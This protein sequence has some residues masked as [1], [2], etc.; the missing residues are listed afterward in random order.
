MTPERR[1]PLR[2]LFTFAGGTGHANPLVP[3][4]RAAEAA[5]HAVAFAGS[6]SAATALEEQGFTL[7]A[8]PAGTPSD[9]A[10]ITRL[11]E[12]DMEHEYRVLRDH[13]AG[14]LARD[15]ARRVLK[16]AE[17]WKPDL[18]V[19]DEVD[20]GSMVAAE[21][22]GL[23]HATVLVVAVGSFVRPDVVAERLDALRAEHGLRPDPDLTM[24]GRHLVV[25]PIPP[26]FRDPAYRLP[27]NAL[28]VQPGTVE[29]AGT[30]LTPS[31]L[32]RPSGRPTVYF[33]LGT[34]FNLESGDLFTRVLSGLRQLPVD[35]VV[36]VGRDIDPGSFGPQ[37]DNVHVEGYV[38]QSALLP[39]CALVV[40]HGGSG[41]VIGALTHGLPMVVIPMGADQPLN[42]ARCEQLG[43]GIA[44]DAV[45]ATPETIREA[46]TTILENP[47]YRAAA[48]RI[49][50]EIVRLPE[51]DAAVPLLE[52][53]AESAHP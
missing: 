21:R 7:F 50:D 36:T 12:L 48:E 42:A 16:L 4:A 37:P 22:L 19:S 2:V 8:E 9:P 45:R 47:S 28:S 32:L 51:P 5:G 53:L 6:R 39:H 38:P 3:I 33:T 34:V 14:R 24:P 26:S 46:V 18:I 1:R 27:P 23:P 40:N 43:V 10:T 49:R 20:F 25:S 29:P 52:R 31:W 17:E 11:L 15:R 44:L 35:V 41:S 30:G 13:Y